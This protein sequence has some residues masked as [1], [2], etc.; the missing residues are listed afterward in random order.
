MFGWNKGSYRFQWHFRREDLWDAAS[1]ISHTLL[2]G[3][4]EGAGK[5]KHYGCGKRKAYV[6]WISL[7]SFNH[8]MLSGW[9]KQFGLFSSSSPLSVWPCCQEN[10]SRGTL[11]QH[12][13]GNTSSLHIRHPSSVWRGSAHEQVHRGQGGAEGS[14]PGSGARGKAAG[15]GRGQGCPASPPRTLM[16]VF[17]S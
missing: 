3:N 9:G 14:R 12:C 7:P 4:S 13:P 10:T 8:T 2:L 11:P 1:G 15:A 5:G 16:S 6:L 17:S